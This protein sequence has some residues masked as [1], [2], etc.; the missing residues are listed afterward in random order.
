MM[1]WQSC[2]VS[3]RSQLQQLLQL[4]LEG[5]ALLLGN[6]A[7]EHLLFDLKVMPP[8]KLSYWLRKACK[9]FLSCLLWSISVPCQL[10]RHTHVHT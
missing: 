10:S 7:N 9:T 2:T 4:H 5:M 8:L 1:P 6:M 3:N